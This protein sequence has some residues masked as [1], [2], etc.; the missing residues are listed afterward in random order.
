MR[1]SATAEKRGYYSNY[2][3]SHAG[4]AKLAHINSGHPV[5][6]TLFPVPYLLSPAVPA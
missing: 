5:F 4:Q 1:T 6:F 2:R 3:D